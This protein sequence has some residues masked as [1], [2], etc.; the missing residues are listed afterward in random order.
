VNDDAVGSKSVGNRDRHLRVDDSL[1]HPH[2]RG[3]A[4]GQLQ[5]QLVVAH[6]ALEQ[7]VEAE[8]GHVVQHGVGCGRRYP[9]TFERARQDVHLPAN[10]SEQKR[11]SDRD[12]QLVAD[13][14]RAL[15]I[16][17]EQKI[18]HGWGRL[19]SLWAAA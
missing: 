7:V 13:G 14:S 9:R 2:R 5:V 19:P 10:D 8:L 11:I 16:P 15:G 12:R 3:G 4:R 17:M 18:G 1:T 6:A